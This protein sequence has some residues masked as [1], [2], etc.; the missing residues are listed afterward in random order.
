MHS[1]LDFE[2]NR[3]K[4]FLKV[5][6]LKERAESRGRASSINLVRNGWGIATAGIPSEHSLTC[7]YGKTKY[8]I[9]EMTIFIHI[10]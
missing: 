2:L 5:D 3:P 8:K 9:I 10:I 4:F 1:I 6:I 7:H